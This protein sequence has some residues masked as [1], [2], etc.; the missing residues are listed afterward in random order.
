[1]PEKLRRFVR[2]Y[3]KMCGNLFITQG[4]GLNPITL[5]TP[6]PKFWS[7][8]NYKKSSFQSYKTTFSTQIYIKIKKTLFGV[9]F[10]V[11]FYP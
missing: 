7:W 4:P 11:N 9:N 10:G 1:M 2:N 5:A 8:C 3:G 6:T